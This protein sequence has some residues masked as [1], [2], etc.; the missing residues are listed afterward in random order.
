[1]LS[2][3]RADS[4]LAFRIE[5][6]GHLPSQRSLVETIVQYNIQSRTISRFQTL[7]TKTTMAKG[8][9]KDQR[10]GF[11]NRIE[12][13][14]IIGIQDPESFRPERFL[15]P[16]DP[17]SPYTYVLTRVWKTHLFRTDFGGL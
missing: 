14:A 7:S 10:T 13:V 12:N 11:S 4:I 6:E 3:E 15:G 17:P 16:D 1:M 8:Y 2:I 9:T 5:S